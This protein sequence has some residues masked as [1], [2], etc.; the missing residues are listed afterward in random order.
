MSS[1]DLP[2]VP[3][4]QDRI[5]PDTLVKIGSGTPRFVLG[6]WSIRGLAAPLRMLLSASGVCYWVAMYDVL[7]DG[8]EGWNMNSWKADKA[9]M[10]QQC[11]PFMN[12]PFLIDVQE[13]EVL[14]QTNALMSYLGRELN[15]MGST[16]L[17]MAKCEELMC[18]IYDVRNT[19]VGFVYGASGTAD[20]CV[21]GA[22]ASMKKLE[23]HLGRSAATCLVGN[24]LT[25]PDFH[26][27]EMLFQYDALARHYKLGDFLESYPKL[28]AYKTCIERLPEL[29]SYLNSSLHKELPFNNVMARFGSD[30]SENAYQRGQ[31]TPWMQQG[32]VLFETK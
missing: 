2:L 12:L 8:D 20:G 31:K 13:Q 27:Y 10:K 19:M 15:M 18:E 24:K 26:L 9:W 22:Q 23:V 28:A 16:K 17:E 1:T 11:N 25:A 14:V 6:Y 4:L 30:P 5:K 32:V 7:E 21:G 29:Q 3:A